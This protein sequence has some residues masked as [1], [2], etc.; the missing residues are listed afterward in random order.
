MGAL[1]CQRGDPEARGGAGQRVP[2]DE[3]P[4]GRRFADVAD[5]NVQLTGWLRRAN[6]R[7]HGTTKVRPA[8]AIWEDRGSM[9][10]I[11]RSNA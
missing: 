2:R 8:E 6:Q 9:L 1:L 7:I 11:Q 4:A 10:T 5:F 3:L